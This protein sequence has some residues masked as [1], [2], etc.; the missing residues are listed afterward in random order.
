MSEFKSLFVFEDEVKEEKGYEVKFKRRGPMYDSYTPEDVKD[1]I[2][3][4][5]SEK[6]RECME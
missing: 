3:A 2:R 4:L 5:Y 6:A 1:E